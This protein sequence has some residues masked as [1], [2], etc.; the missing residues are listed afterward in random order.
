MVNEEVLGVIEMASFHTLKPFEIQFIR[1]IAQG[2]AITIRNMQTNAK[3]QSLLEESR[4]ATEELKAKED[5]LKQNSTELIKI[6]EALNEKL[7][8]IEKESAYTQS[9]VT[10]INSTNASL[11][12]DLDGTIMDVNEMFLSIMEYTRE[13]LIG[14]KEITFVAEDEIVTERYQMM[15]GSVKD[16]AYNSGEFRRINKSGRELWISGSYSPIFDVNGNAYKIVL[17]AQFTTE[18][19]EKELELKSKIEAIN[20]SIP[21]IELNLDLSVI[22][23]NPIFLKD[24]GYKR[25]DMRN[26]KI[27]FVLEPNYTQSDEF[28]VLWDLVSEDNVMTQP[29]RM[30]TKEG[31]IKHYIANFSPTKNLIGQV[32][33]V[34]VILIDLTEQ[35]L[36]K[37]QLNLLLKEEKRKTALLELKIDANEATFVE[38]LVEV[39]GDFENSIA[40]EKLNLLISSNNIP[41]LELDKQTNVSDANVSMLNLLG[42]K[43]ET[44]INTSFFDLVE[45][46]E[47]ELVQTTNKIYSNTLCQ[48]KFR[49]KLTGGSFIYLNV[50]IIPII[51][52][53]KYLVIVLNEEPTSDN[54]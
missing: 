11:V 39:L 48:F 22:T 52:Q 41:T 37:E 27:D 15:I 54:N 7:V 32:Y 35:N 29:L 40:L 1:Q 10:A 51:K 14:K 18:Q 5:D 4:K 8:E 30:I 28:V 12:M 43:H 24:F 46:D 19:K 2:F 36:L 44:C 20:S 33:K 38:E 26:K 6:Q 31:I 13:E 45:V 25:M 53:D 9:I 42:L 21:T 3:T 50:Y 16:G 49:F 17:F 23:A 34:L 47:N